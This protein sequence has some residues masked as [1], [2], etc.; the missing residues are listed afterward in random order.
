[1]GVSQDRRLLRTSDDFL[2]L[3]DNDYHGSPLLSGEGTKLTSLLVY[4]CVRARVPTRD[5]T[6]VV[7][8]WGSQVSGFTTWSMIDKTSRPV[9]ITLAFFDCVLCH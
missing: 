4:V 9:Y 2:L 5:R 7:E 8:M 3:S 1:M 6:R